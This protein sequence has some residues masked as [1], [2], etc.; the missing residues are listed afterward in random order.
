MRGIAWQDDADA[1]KQRSP[2]SGDAGLGKATNAGAPMNPR[3]AL[4]AQL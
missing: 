3:S 4:R 1:L 2:E